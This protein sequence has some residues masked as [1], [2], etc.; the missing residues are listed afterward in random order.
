L[1]VPDGPITASSFRLCRRCQS[2]LIS[3]SRPKKRPASFSVKLE[4]PGYGLRSS[5]S[6]RTADPAGAANT[7]SSATRTSRPEPYLSSRPCSRHRRTIPDT[8]GA[9][10]RP[11]L[12][13]SAGSS[14]RIAVSVATVVSRRNGCLPESSSYSN[15]P[16]ENTSVRASI[17]RPRTCSGDMNPIV[18]T[19]CPASVGEGSVASPLSLV[20]RVAAFA[21]PK[22]S[23]FTRPSTVTITFSGFTSRCTIPFACAASSPA[24]ACTA[25]ASTCRCVGTRRKAISRSV[26]PCSSS[27]TT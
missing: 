7:A 24:A 6:S 12:D 2:A 25:K 21:R 27:I 26:S 18:P 17:A 8:A 11:R 20:S 13:S 5:T 15:T 3:A 23:T 9:I 4:S 19:T 16:N 22:S 14:S 1:P 10:P